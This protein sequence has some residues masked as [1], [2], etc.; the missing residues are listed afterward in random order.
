MND[1]PRNKGIGQKGQFY[2]REKAW[3]DGCKCFTNVSKGS[4]CEWLH[5]EAFDKTWNVLLFYI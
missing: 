2:D 4:E 5:S 3:H 1:S